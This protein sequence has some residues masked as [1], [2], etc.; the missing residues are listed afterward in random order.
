[1]YRGCAFSNALRKS[2][3]L[4]LCVTAPASLGWSQQA[5]IAPVRPSAPAIVR[6]YLVHTVPPIRL[7]NSSRLHELI[8]AGVLY[9]TARDA[10]ALALENNIDIE[11]ARYNS[12]LLA[13]RLERAQAGGALPGVPSGATQAS[14][15]ANGQGVAGS[16][17]AAGVSATGNAG[18]AGTAGNATISQIGP[19]TPTLDP[20]VQEASTFSHKSAPQANN[21]QSLTLNLTSGSRVLNA[22]YTQ[23]LIT[24]GT[25]SLNYSD[26]FLNEN[27]PSDVL[28]PTVAPNLSFSFQH[29]LLQ[30]F[31]VAVN[32]RNITI[33]RINYKRS[34]LEFK[35]QVVSTVA[36]VLNAY[37]AVLADYE[38]GKAKQSALELARTLL[39]DNQR[40]VRI[41]S[42]AP[43]DV[44][45]AEA[46]TA[47]AERDLV[48]SQTNLQQDETQLKNLLS[49]TGIADPVLAGARIVPL[50]RITIPEKDDLPPVDQLVKQAYAN[51]SDLASQLVNEKN[52]EISSIGTRNGILPVGVAIGGESQ[53]GLAGTP[54]TVVFGKFVETAN[55]Y[56]VGGIGNG[57]G[58]VLRRDF[59]SERIGIFALAPIHNW[60]AQADYGIVQLQLRQTQLSTAKQFNQVQVDVMNSV[61]A[62]QQARARYDAAVRNRTLDEQLLDAE[63]KKARLGASTPYNVITE[64]RDLAAAQSAEIAAL[65]TYANARVALDQILGMTLEANGISIEEAKQG[66]VSR[67]SSLAES[68]K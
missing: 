62:L 58:Q 31:G 40:Q 10:I 22:T 9:L 12:P 64:Q 49:R 47:S 46:Q 65:V 60:Q 57:L 33:A 45:S 48:I 24:G 61:V 39:D 15:V 5:D 54:R 34:D 32:A 38:D 50:D 36:A 13:W 41:G 27:A 59:P 3:A 68:P 25:V 44:T 18:G 35:T 37:Y 4:G 28:N 7:A 23:G 17:A 53:A 14:S 21:V 42:L 29:N 43:L 1:M 16:Q 6:P 19:V 30:G 52:A 66:K 55:P 20:T 67:T 63:Q 26:H 56:F 8:R 51:R 11:V 2:I